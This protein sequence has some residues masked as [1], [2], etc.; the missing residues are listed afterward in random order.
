M[1]QKNLA[2]FLQLLKERADTS[3]L[4]Q[5]GLTYSQIATLFSEGLRQ[6][7]IQKNER[8]FV[9]TEKGMAF[10]LNFSLKA[11]HHGHKWVFPDDSYKI[12]ALEID[13]IYLPSKKESKF[14]R[15]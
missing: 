5:Q 10:L 6:D 12:P 7:L 8:S 9:V 15:T 1:N 11:G 13:D 4:T 3:F 14:F 2:L